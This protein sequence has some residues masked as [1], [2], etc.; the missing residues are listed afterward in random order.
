MVV[1]TLPLASSL[2]F[3]IRISAG[4]GPPKDGRNSDGASSTRRWTEFELAKPSS[5]EDERNSEC[6]V[7]WVIGA[8]ESRGNRGMFPQFW[9]GL[10]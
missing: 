2:A 8:Q 7:H 9:R 1:A 5:L 6:L 3:V 4:L 10:Y